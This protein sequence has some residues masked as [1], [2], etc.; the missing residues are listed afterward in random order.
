MKKEQ[1]MLTNQCPE[2]NIGMD[3]LEGGVYRC[4]NCD[5]VW[6]R[7]GED[8]KYIPDYNG[9]VL[10][11]FTGDVSDLFIVGGEDSEDIG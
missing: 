9:Y 2:C 4:P 8:F 7:A 1:K 5:M 10:G 11:A 6:V 3:D